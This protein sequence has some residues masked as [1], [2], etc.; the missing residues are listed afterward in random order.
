MHTIWNWHTALVAV[1]AMAAASIVILVSGCETLGAT[2][3]EENQGA[4]RDAREFLSVGQTTREQ[5]AAKYGQAT[6]VTPLEGGGEHWEYRRREAV[7]MN[8]YSNTPIGTEGRMTR[9]LGGYQHSVVRTTRLELFF[10]AQGT[11]A[12]YRLDRGLH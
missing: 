5:V 9:P 8:A 6:T 7:V 4:Y 11:L 1:S 3:L 10:D 2:T 12:H